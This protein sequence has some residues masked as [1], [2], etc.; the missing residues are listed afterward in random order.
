MLNKKMIAKVVV[1]LGVG[2]GA[3]LVGGVTY[4]LFNASPTAGGIFLSGIVL[5]P[6]GVW[7]LQVLYDE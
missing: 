4:T 3:I 5:V 1:T 2:F 7:A 6:S